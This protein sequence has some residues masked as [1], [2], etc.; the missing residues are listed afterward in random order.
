MDINHLD[1]QCPLCNNVDRGLPQHR[2][3]IRTT[4]CSNWRVPEMDCRLCD[5]TEMS[6]DYYR[7]HIKLYCPGVRNL[8]RS[9]EADR[10][11]EDEVQDFD[12]LEQPMDKFDM[13]AAVNDEAVDEPIDDKKRIYQVLQ[14]LKEMFDVFWLT[15]LSNADI[16]K[17][18]VSVICDQ[19]HQLL[20]K[21]LEC[22]NPTTEVF[23]T[24]M[25]NF[26]ALWAKSQS[27]YQRQTELYK[28]GTFIQPVK[29][30]TKERTETVSNTHFY[31]AVI[32]TDYMA[33]IPIKKTLNAILSRQSSSLVMPSSHF[34]DTSYEHVFS[35]E[36]SR[37]LLQVTRKQINNLFHI[38][39]FRSWIMSIFVFKFIWM[40]MERQIR[41]RR[42]Q[43]PF[44]K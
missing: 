7:N 29:Y 30:V 19:V 17:K 18:T 44:T 42:Q 27:E 11:F 6:Y 21:S 37:Q 24:A 34:M 1:L 40:I 4:H 14:E 31:N 26:S 10:M 22:L 3:H 5:K 9:N 32:K 28:T 8:L 39:C 33:Y 20:E 25:E 15:L 36:R 16:T 23:D 43:L 12:D 13:N 35:G 41:C 2:R 38:C